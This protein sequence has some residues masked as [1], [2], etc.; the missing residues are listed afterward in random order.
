MCELDEQWVEIRSDSKQAA[1]EMNSIRFQAEH[2]PRVGLAM[3]LYVDERPLQSHIRPVEDRLVIRHNLPADRAGEYAG[4][5]DLKAVVWP[6]LHF[7]GQPT[8]SWYDDGDTILLGCICGVAECR[9][10]LAY[11]DVGQDIVVWHNFKLGGIPGWDLSPVGP[12]E[13][14]REGYLAALR[15]TSRDD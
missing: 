12:F 4:I 15:M 1:R 11:I 3:S 13:F 6:S 5:V 2:D 7:Y 8:F 10:L 14:S 9:P